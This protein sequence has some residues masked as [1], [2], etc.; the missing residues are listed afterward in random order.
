MWIGVIKA[1]DRVFNL[2]SVVAKAALIFASNVSVR[3]LEF[4][5]F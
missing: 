4:L 2:F 3:K 1:Y 5:G